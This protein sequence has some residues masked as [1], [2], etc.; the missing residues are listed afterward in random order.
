MAV[1][2]ARP[3]VDPSAEDLIAHCGGLIAAYKRPKSIEFIDALPVLASGKVD[4]VALR[5]K[6]CA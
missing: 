2:V 5:A 1:V 6:F 3:G 4:K